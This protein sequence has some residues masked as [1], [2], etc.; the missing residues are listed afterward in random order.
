MVV[1]VREREPAQVLRRT[2][3]G[4]TYEPYLNLTSCRF[5]GTLLHPVSRG[6]MMRR[7]G[8]FQPGYKVIVEWPSSLEAHPVLPEDVLDIGGRA[9]PVAGCDERP[10][11]YLDIYVRE[12]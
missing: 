3:D 5:M 12:A 2:P 11:C 6:D 4:Q 9:F 8:V 10:G 7:F 1:H